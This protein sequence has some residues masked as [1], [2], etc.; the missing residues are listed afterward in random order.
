MPRMARGMM[1]WADVKRALTDAQNYWV[2]TTGADGT[3]QPTPVWAVWLDDCLW[4]SCGRETV[5]ARNIAARPQVA[6]HLESGDH[7]VVVRGTAEPIS[8]ED[9]SRIIAAMQAKYGADS[10]PDSFDALAGLG[11]C[12]RPVGILSWSAFPRDVTHW[13]PPEEART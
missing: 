2:V 6:I 13:D 5:K 4:F 12:V 3:P 7:P 10:V 9:E 8:D 11:F 1:P